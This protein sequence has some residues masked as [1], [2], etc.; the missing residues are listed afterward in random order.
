[1]MVVEKPVPAAKTDVTGNRIILMII[2]SDQIRNQLDFF[3]HELLLPKYWRLISCQN[4][5]MQ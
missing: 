5:A 3:I 4:H 2:V 1:V